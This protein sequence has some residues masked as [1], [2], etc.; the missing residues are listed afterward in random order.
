MN[1]LK[2]ALAS[3][4]LLTFSVQAAAQTTNP[5][6]TPVTITVKIGEKTLKATLQDNETTRD[7]LSLLPLTLTLEDYA[8]TEKITYPPRKLSTKG[9]PAGSTPKTGDIAYYAPW[10]NLAL[11]HKD[12]SYSSGLIILGKLDSGVDVLRQPGKVTVT[13]EQVKK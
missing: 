5:R 4:A 8:S 2:A 6:R 10:G 9:A 12:F 1:R 13:I 11:F 3:L 7:L